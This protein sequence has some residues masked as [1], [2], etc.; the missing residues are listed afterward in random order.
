[1]V[2]FERVGIDIVRLLI[3]STSRHEFI[4]VLVD[5]ATRYPEAIPTRNMR[6]ESGQGTGPSLHP[7]RNT[8]ASSNGSK[9]VVCERSA[10]SRMVVL[11][12]A[13][14]VHLHVPAPDQRVGG[15]VQWNAEAHA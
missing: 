10:P 11:V 7:N 3:Q 12:G 8:Q 15:K 6:A 13:A 1:M 2:P 9:V 5:Y 14:P 4:L